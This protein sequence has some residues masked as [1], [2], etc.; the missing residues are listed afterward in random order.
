[1]KF[2]LLQG[3]FIVLDGPDGCGKSTQSQLLKELMI[4]NG[5][6]VVGVRDPGSTS[7]GEQIREILLSNDN[8]EMNVRCET[9]LY[10]ASRSQLYGQ[11]IAPAL[12]EGKCVVCDRWVSSTY[13][14][15]AVA[16]GIGRETL[17]DLAEHCLE[18]TWP[19][20]TIIIDMPMERS[21]SRIG[22]NP[23]RMESKGD[24]FHRKVRDAY[25]ELADKY[26]NI[27]VIDGNG[28]IQEVHK[29]VLLVLDT[30]FN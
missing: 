2:E 14:Y 6:E 5:V 8:A 11:H 18:R 27:Y 3:K 21:M 10:M 9:L 29:R 30:I 25:V 4:S 7:I 15:Q 26:E 19:D 13:A 20:V 16:G 17:L 24:E 22:D 1:M 12:A 23:D 28:S